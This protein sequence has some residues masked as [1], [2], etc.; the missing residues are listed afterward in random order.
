MHLNLILAAQEVGKSKAGEIAYNL[1]YFVG[2][3]FWTIVSVAVVLLA[4]ILYL[5]FFRS[6][7]RNNWG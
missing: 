6:R 5:I 1:G 3:N 2:S 7:K 4:A